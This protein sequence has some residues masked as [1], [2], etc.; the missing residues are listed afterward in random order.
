MKTYFLL[1]EAYTVWTHKE[2]EDALSSQV[3]KKPQLKC[4]EKYHH[5]YQVMLSRK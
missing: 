2:V 3:P 1:E 4:R 5:T